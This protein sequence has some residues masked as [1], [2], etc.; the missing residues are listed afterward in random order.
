MRKSCVTSSSCIATIFLRHQVC[1][2]APSACTT[3][4]R[5]KAIH[6]MVEGKLSDRWLEMERLRCLYLKA[7]SQECVAVTVKRQ[8]A[9]HVRRILSTSGL[10]QRRLRIMPTGLTR[11]ILSTLTRCLYVKALS[12]E[13]VKMLITP[14]RGTLCLLL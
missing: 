14:G 4:C 5:S 2:G 3:F 11:R 12:Q 1:P 6:I 7:L 13:C 10:T 9:R 8:S